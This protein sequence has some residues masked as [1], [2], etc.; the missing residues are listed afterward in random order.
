MSD[1]KVD[2][3]VYLDIIRASI[4]ELNG[5]MDVSVKDRAKD[6]VKSAMGRSVRSKDPL[7]WPAGM[8]M[9]GLVEARR[10]L[11]ESLSDE[12]KSQELV[13]EIDAAILK[14]LGFWKHKNGSKIEYIDDALAGTALIRLY[15]QSYDEALRQLCKDAIDKILDYLMKAPRDFSGTIVYNAERD[16]SNVFADGIGQVSMFLSAYGSSFDNE[17][18]LKL[19]RL[20]L[21]NFKKYGM[22]DRSGLPYHGYALSKDYCEKKGVLSWGRAAGWLIMGL[23]EYSSVMRQRSSEN[24][25]DEDE[26]PEISEKDELLEWYESLSENL[27]SYQRPDGGYGWQIQAREGHLDT[28]ATGMIVYGLMNGLGDVDDL[29]M[30]EALESSFK[31]MSLNIQEGKVTDALSSCDDF[32]VHYQTYGHYPWGQGAVLAALTWC[33]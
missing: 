16:G 25:W 14:H 22:D 33:W 15:Q 29:E 28:S 21:L 23:S 7:F 32:G 4:T 17:E 8:L 10:T 9:L 3:A 11:L 6:L 5:I 31:T 19:A 24:N 20:Q 1:F 30:K 12:E 2:T 13:A 26:E 18:A 27:V